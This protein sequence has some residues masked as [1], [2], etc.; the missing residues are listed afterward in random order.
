MC[1]G[2]LLGL[3]CGGAVAPLRGGLE[4]DM[5]VT[6]NRASEENVEVSLFLASSS[7]SPD[8]QHQ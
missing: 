7:H 3:G 6:E 5:G 2:L 4:G 8:F 1:W